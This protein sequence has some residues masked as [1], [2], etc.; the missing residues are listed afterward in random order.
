MGQDEGD[1]SRRAAEAA[2]LLADWVKDSV[3]EDEVARV[4]EVVDLQD[5]SA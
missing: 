5:R 3:A 1:A 4:A 2:G